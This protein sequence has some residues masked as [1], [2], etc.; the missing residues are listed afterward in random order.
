MTV[1]PAVMALVKRYGAKSLINAPS[2]PKANDDAEF[3]AAGFTEILHVDLQAGGDVVAGD[4]AV[5]QPP[6]PYDMLYINCFFC[7]TSTTEEQDGIKAKAAVN[8]AR[9]PVRVI[10]VYDTV[11]NDKFDW[12]QAFRS[13]GRKLIFR[14]SRLDSGYTRL[15]AWE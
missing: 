8:M 1:T 10:I 15:E 7:L 12:E 9:W 13:A 2:G 3:R 5:Y 6:K 11:Y 4:L 14:D